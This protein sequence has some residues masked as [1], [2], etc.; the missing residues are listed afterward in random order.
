MINH[1][2]WY[3]KLFKK[4]VFKKEDKSKFFDNKNENIFTGAY[5][6]PVRE[7]G[8]PPFSQY[9]FNFI[10]YDGDPREERSFNS[11]LFFATKGGHFALD[12]EM[13]SLVKPYYDVQSMM[14]GACIG[15]HM[16]LV[17]LA[18]LMGGFVTNKFI[19]LARVAGEE[20]INPGEINAFQPYLREKQRA[21][22]NLCGN[23]QW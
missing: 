7:Y 15:R 13:V 18:S 21:E 22:Y 17:E 6:H 2:N 14:A 16:E 3:N 4:L 12:S 20:K 9:V 23:W 1:I 19:S 11:E 10:F 5:S 8:M